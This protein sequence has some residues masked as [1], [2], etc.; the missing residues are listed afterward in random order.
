MS[1]AAETV[2]RAPRGSDGPAQHPPT[3][4]LCHR[5]R[6]RS[7]QHHP[8]PRR[9]PPSLLH[10]QLGAAEDSQ[11]ASSQLPD[12]NHHTPEDLYP[13][14]VSPAQPANGHYAATRDSGA[15]R[16]RSSPGGGH[17]EPTAAARVIQLMPSAIM[18]P[19]LL[20]PGRAGAGGDYRHGRGAMH[21][22]PHENERDG[23][24]GKGAWQQHHTLSSS[25]HHPHQHHHHQLGQSGHP[26]HPQGHHAHHQEEGRFRNHV[27]VPV[28]PPEDQGMPI[29]RIAGEAGKLMP[30]QRVTH[31]HTHTHTLYVLKVKCCYT[32]LISLLFLS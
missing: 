18:H 3:I 10:P 16:G 27:I 24:G 32:L 21:A 30:L 2:R 6:S 25:H 19:L 11:Q 26:H 5:H 8:G 12:S 28:S 7:P 14:S 4:E 15:P 1:L 23:H 13:L 31:T 29:G 22:S 9:S 20:S 17:E